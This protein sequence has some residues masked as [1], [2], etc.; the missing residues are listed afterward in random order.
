[1][2]LWPLANK[3]LNKAIFKIQK[4]GTAAAIKFDKNREELC[5]FFFFFFTV[6][7]SLDFFHRTAFVQ[8]YE[9]LQD[10][11]SKAFLSK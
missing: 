1:M 6:C 2:A 11:Y 8:L 3:A 10:R 9:G 4:L 5:Y 7:P